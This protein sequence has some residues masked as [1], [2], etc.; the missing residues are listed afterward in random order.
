M[1]EDGRTVSGWDLRDL[2]GGVWWKHGGLIAALGQLGI[3]GL[4]KVQERCGR[5]AGPYLAGT[6]VVCAEGS[7]GTVVGGL[8]AESET[9]VVA[10]KLFLV[11]NF[12]L[13]VAP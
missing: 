3:G 8:V 2:R 11:A 4:T 6:G 5:M 7:G 10:E 1:R 9:T 12:G 13:M